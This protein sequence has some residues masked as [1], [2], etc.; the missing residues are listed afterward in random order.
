MTLR[1]HRCHL[2]VSALICACSSAKADDWMVRVQDGSRTCHVQR[3]TA[4]PM[5]SDL[6]GPFPSRLKA[7][8]TAS[9][10]YDGSL[11]DQTKCYTYGGGTVDGCK[12]DGIK[13]PPK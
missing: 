5:G 8:Q 9:D 11:T 3:K 7:C 2:I 6:K 1:V 4:S 13:L 12:S 10:L